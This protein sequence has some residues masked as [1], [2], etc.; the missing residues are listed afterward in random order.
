MLFVYYVFQSLFVNIQVGGIAR[1][2]LNKFVG[3][4]RMLEEAIMRCRVEVLDSVFG[5][6][7]FADKEHTSHKVF[8]LISDP[9]AQYQFSALDFVSEWVRDRVVELA[10][11]REISCMVKFVLSTA[12]LGP[13]G[14]LRGST[15]EGLAH[16]LLSK[17]G[18][19]L[20]RALNT[21]R[22]ETCSLPC[23]E[24][25]LITEWEQVQNCPENFYFRPVSKVLKAVD[26]LE[27]PNVVFQMTMA[28][29]HPIH[30]S[31][32]VESIEKL[33]CTGPIFL[34]F[35]LPA[36]RFYDFDKQEFVWPRAPQNESQ[37]GKLSRE[38]SQ[39]KGNE[40]LGRVQQFAL[41]IDCRTLLPA[42]AGS[43]IRMRKWRRHA[44]K[45]TERV[46][47]VD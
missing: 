21:G 24:Q 6:E 5:I 47:K 19:F 18:E 32:L 25:K 22:E 34:Y 42:E 13:L 44:K 7:S 20:V 35:P 2:V 14:T 45:S 23:L 27:L 40:I 16:R 3:E 46:S 43:L 28:P 31:G 26:A 15:F 8:Q 12:G 36:D 38:A 11:Q 10:S 1:Y 33:G 30:A 39:I 17:G 41:L 4:R 9:Q 29:T 37:S